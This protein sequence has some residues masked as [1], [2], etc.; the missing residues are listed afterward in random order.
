MRPGKNVTALLDTS[1]FKSV[2]LL[3]Y[4]I[5]FL[6]ACVMLRPPQTHTRDRAGS[7]LSFGM[8]KNGMWPVLLAVEDKKKSILL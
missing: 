4:Y 6:S 1:T 8:Q 7:Y 5:L 2:K 3:T